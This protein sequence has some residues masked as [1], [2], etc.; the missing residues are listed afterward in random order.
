MPADVEREPQLLLDSLRDPRRRAAIADVVEEDGELVAAQAGHGVVDAKAADEPRGEADQEPVSR[1]VAQ[2]VV[3]E[4]ETVEVEEEHG[5]AVLV[6]PAAVRHGLTQTVEEQRP[7]GQSG[8]GIV[9][10]V[11]EDLRLRLLAE[12]DVGLR[13]GDADVLALR[14]LDHEAAAQHEEVVA[15]PG[16]QA[17]LALEMGGAAF[18]V[19]LE[20]RADAFLVLGVNAVQP[21]VGAV[22]DLVLLEAEHRL[23]PRR[24]VDPAGLEVPVPEAVVGPLGRH[25]VALFA[26]VEGFVDLPQV[27]RGSGEAPYPEPMQAEAGQHDPEPGQGLER[28]G[29]RRSEDGGG[30]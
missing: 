28:R 4:L 13:A 5:E 12:G 16:P 27:A 30:C 18:E 23:P 11:V 3:H 26:L 9:E 2:A 14:V 10:G 29:S 1:E 22:R 6:P 24:V 17:M 15:F 8:E 19:S 21:L 25:R 20:A 7:V